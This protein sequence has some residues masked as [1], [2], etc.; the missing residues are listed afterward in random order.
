MNMAKVEEIL[1]QMK[2]NPKDIR[3]V[4]LRK[5]CDFYFGK[6][7]HGGGSHRIYNPNVAK[8]EDA[9]DPRRQG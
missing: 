7:R 3:F 8:V 5:V 6:A 1:A 2:R 9:V 4:D